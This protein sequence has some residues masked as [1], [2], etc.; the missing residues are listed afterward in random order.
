MDNQIKIK[1]YAASIC[2]KFENLLD[3]HNIDIPDEDRE[4]GDGEARI[5]GSTYA[6]LEEAVGEV[7]VA[8]INEVKSNINADIDKYSY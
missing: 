3:E 6:A 5:Y 1:Q 4:G 8:L 2:D 7:L